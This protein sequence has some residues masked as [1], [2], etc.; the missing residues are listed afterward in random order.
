M[1]E[2]HQLVFLLNK[3]NFDKYINSND[4]EKFEYIRRVLNGK[5]YDDSL[6]RVKNVSFGL[7][8]FVIFFNR[9]NDK[10]EGYW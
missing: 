8:E 9:T 4:N 10:L 7:D 1:T 3:I 5:W 6:C 2:I